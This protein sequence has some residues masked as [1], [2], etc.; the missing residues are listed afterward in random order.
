MGLFSFFKTE[1]K[2]LHVDSPAYEQLTHYCQTHN[3]RV[4]EN[5]PLYHR[6]EEQHL[7]L[8]VFDPHRG[9]YL[10]E[11]LDWRFE[12]IK[13]ATVSPAMPNHK[14]RDINVDAKH[15]F[16]SRKF[17]EILHTDGCTITNFI[18]CDT[19]SEL[20]FDLLDESFH[21]LLPKERIIFADSD[22]AHI[23]TKLE[24]A[25]ELQSTSLESA[26]LLGALFFHMAVLPD[27]L[28]SAFHLLTD[29]QFAFVTSPLPLKS[30]LNGTY[31]SGKSSAILLKA[32]YE[33]L[34]KPSLKI[35]IVEPSVAACEL[36]KKRLLEI[37]EYAIIDIDMSS[38][39]IL[40]P[41]QVIAQ[42]YQKLYKKESFRFA[43]I[44][45]KMLSH[46]HQSADIIFC[47][48][49]YLL[50]HE[51]I[52]YLNFQQKQGALCL[53]ANSDSDAQYQLTHAFRTP[54][55]FIDYC[56]PEK[57]APTSNNL[58]VLEG[59]PFMHIMVVLKEQL[60]NCDNSQILIAVPH[61]AFAQKLLDEISGFYGNIAT[62]YNADEGL[63]Y[64]EMDQLI[65]APINTLSHLQRRRVIVI[66]DGET[67]RLYFCHALGRAAHSLYII[68]DENAESHK[69]SGGVET[70]A[71]A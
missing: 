26:K 62:I 20:E 27:N 45:P 9:I 60:K 7:A 14:T 2:P 41:Q 66:D 42:H 43:K 3:L 44:T 19:L 35:I 17:N 49:A 63:L 32:I 59:N 39:F 23:R 58:V 6:Q 55:A 22:E 16:L 10:F 50:D 54:N 21:Q 67:D 1:D 36:L 52:K 25:L 65:I 24:A 51:F 71:L 38:I 53:V 11:R 4:F 56:N 34:Q 5:I 28:D 31:G 30:T 15:A 57:E 48:D 29:E 47:D 40:T 46:R 18:I 70:P 37:I 69:E 33:L 64:Q 68:K 12:A 61:N 13:N 8:M